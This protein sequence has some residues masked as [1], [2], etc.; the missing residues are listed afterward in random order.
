PGLAEQRTHPDSLRFDHRLSRFGRSVRKLRPPGHHHF[1]AAFGGR[2]RAARAHAD[3]DGAE[4]DRH[5]RHHS[6]D[7]PGEE[8]RHHHDRF[9]PAMRTAGEQEF[10]RFHLRGMPA[11][12]P[13]HHDD[14]DGGDAGRGAPG[15]RHGHRFGAAPSPGNHDY[16]RVAGQP[17]I[18]PLYNTL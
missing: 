3:Q 10:A 1:D 6:A 2:R 17:G 14:H 15:D 9:R 4:R 18:D 11:P 12:I 16:R 13:S 7:R 5:H 8:E